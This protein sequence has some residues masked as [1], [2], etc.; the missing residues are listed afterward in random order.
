MKTDITVKF[1]DFWPSFD[2][3]N[4]KF[5]RVLRM[6]RGVTVLPPNSSEKPDL[7]FYSRCGIGNHYNYN[8]CVKIFYTGENDYPNFNECDYAISFH[9]IEAN[10]RNLRYPLYAL[11][12]E[13]TEII[14]IEDSKAVSRPFCSMVMSNSSMCDPSRLSI[15]EAVNAYQPIESGGAYQNTI[16]HRVDNKQSF[17]SGFKFNLALENSML[18]GYVTEKIADAFCAST[19]PIYWGGSKVKSDF[20]PSSF[21]NVTDYNSMDDF[22]KDLKAINAD[23]DRYLEMLHQPSYMYETIDRF[24]CQ[25]EE[26]LNLIADAPKIFR[27]DYGE[28]GLFRR[29]YSIL[30]PLAQRRSFIR[31]SRLI[32]QIL[33]SDYYKQRKN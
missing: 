3:E 22:I 19:V 10:G 5:V 7:L 17:I 25:L 31:L 29:R 20:N 15:Y 9:D 33:M 18:D 16:G 28:M 2:H 1:I 23:N 8:D 6:H 11:E 32:G 14:N 30:H 27:T 21:I 12:S 26:Y 4:N 24:D 13:D